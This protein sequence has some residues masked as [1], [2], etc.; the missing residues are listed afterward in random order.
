[1]LYIMYIV[2]CAHK[3]TAITFINISKAHT[4]IHL[5]LAT[6][7][8]IAVSAF[9]CQVPIAL[10]PIASMTSV[11]DLARELGDVKDLIEAQVQAGMNRD[12]VMEALFTS[13]TSRLAA[14]GK[15]TPKAKTILTSAIQRGPWN[16]DQRRDLAS[17]V[18]NGTK[19]NKAKSAADNRRPMQKA[20]RFENLISME[21]MA[22]L[23]NTT[24]FS[25]TSRMSIM[26]AAA[27]QIG[28]ECADEPTLF[29]MVAIIAH[30][31]NAEFSQQQVWDYM[32][33]IQTFIKSVPRN[34]AIPYQGLYPINASLLPQEVQKIAWPNGEI[35]VELDLH[36]ELSCVLGTAKQRG[37]PSTSTKKAKKPEWLTAV[38]EHLRDAV[39]T[40]VQGQQPASGASG[41]TD[42]PQQGMSLPSSPAPAPIAD[43]FRFSAL[44]AKPAEPPA[45]EPGAEA[46]AEEEEAEEEADTNTIDELEQS[47]VN[48]LRGRA[49]GRGA[50][51]R[52]AAA[53]RRPA[54]STANV[55]KKPAARATKVAQACSSKD[56]NVRK[57]LWRHVH[58]R[59]YSKV[60]KDEHNKHGND[61]LAKKRASAACAK[62]KAKF[63]RGQLK[64]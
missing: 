29:R 36:S 3:Q 6:L 41:S 26:A 38:P 52:P 37:R 17:V 54:S 4:S 14:C 42:K 46:G 22:K 7:R 2:G 34:T 19:G 59:I 49:P 12:E 20:H 25:R 63:L 9:L 60:R 40:A 55:A 61:E 10:L 32:D 44:E 13:W 58:S 11:E 64:L 30:C 28:I 23:K 27:R 50:R 57:A 51:K 53:M 62:A 16:G 39:M 31:E 33:A 5:Q 45:P 24:K 8:A 35:P 21:V 18:L 47:M 43:C 15:M 56:P 48:A 1:M